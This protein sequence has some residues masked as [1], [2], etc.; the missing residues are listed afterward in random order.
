LLAIA[1]SR[2]GPNLCE[3]LRQFLKWW[4][5]G[6]RRAADP[7]T[8]KIAT[9]YGKW[10]LELEQ[11]KKVSQGRRA[12]MLSAVRRWGAFLA[13]SHLMASN[14]YQRVTGPA[15]P[16]DIALACLSEEAV[17]TRLASMPTT[18]VIQLRHY[19]IALLMVRTGVRETELCEANVGHVTPI[20]DVAVLHVWTKGKQKTKTPADFVVLRPDV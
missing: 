19:V 8:T 18:T 7:L 5:K 9:A 4:E 13:T 16:Q 6:S 17:N 10:L 14:P 15:K 1:I 3:C 12:V 11:A 20:G 2:N